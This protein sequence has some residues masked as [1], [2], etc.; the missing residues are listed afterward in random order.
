MKDSGSRESFGA[1]AAIRDAGEGKPQIH[2]ISPYIWPH[3]SPFYGIFI[4]DYLLTGEIVHMYKLMLTL[5]R[6]FGYERLCEWLRIGAIKYEKYNWAKGMPISRCLDSLGRHL[7]AISEKRKDE[8]HEAAAMCNTMFIIHFHNAVGS[9]LID[10]RFKDIFEYNR[11][12]NKEEK[13][14]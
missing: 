14:V 3:I 12:R 13:N 8:D 4:K 10:S 5:L 6:E 9:G 7:I 2:L 11:L 1:D